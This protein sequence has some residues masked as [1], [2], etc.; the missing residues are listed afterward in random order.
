M[1]SFGINRK[2]V[3]LEKSINGISISIKYKLAKPINF[4]VGK[5]SEGMFICF[6]SYCLFL[7]VSSFLIH[8]FS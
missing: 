2:K 7:K 8:V 4:L 1:F 5:C 6:N 3:A